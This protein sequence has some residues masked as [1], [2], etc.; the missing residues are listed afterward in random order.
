MVEHNMIVSMYV[1][2]DFSSEFSFQIRFVWNI[3]VD[4]EFWSTF[5]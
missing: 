5:F 2:V 3:L 1:D 4:N